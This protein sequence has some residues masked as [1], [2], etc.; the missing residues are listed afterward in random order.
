MQQSRTVGALRYAVL[1]PHGMNTAD[2]AARQPAWGIGGL[3]L[4]AAPPV[5]EKGRSRAITWG[6]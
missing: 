3:E 4:E 2:A 5:Q 1:G 6:E